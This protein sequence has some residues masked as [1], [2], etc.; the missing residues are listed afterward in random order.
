MLSR[1]ENI[2]DFVYQDGPLFFP[3]C[4]LHVELLSVRRDS[5]GPGCPQ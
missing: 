1:G 2:L 3:G 5:E 4:N